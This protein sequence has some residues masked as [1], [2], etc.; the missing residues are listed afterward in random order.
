MKLEN[1][2]KTVKAI[3]SYKPKKKMRKPDKQPSKAELNQRFKI[4][5][6]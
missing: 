1:F 6:K 2:A 5:I 4:R 3:A